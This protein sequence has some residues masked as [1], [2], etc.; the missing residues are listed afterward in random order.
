MSYVEVTEEG[1]FSRIKNSIKGIV[2]GFILFMAAFP[3]LLWNECNA[4]EVAESLEEGAGAV[5]SV[6][7][8]KIDASKEG[9]LIHTTGVVQTKDALRDEA[10]GVAATGVKLE[11]D[12]EIYQWVE[13]CSSKSE[14]KLGGKKVTE[15]TCDYTQEWRESAVDSS[16]FKDPKYKKRNQGTSLV[17]EKEVIPAKNVTVGAFKLTADQIESWNLGPEEK[18][19]VEQKHLRAARDRKGTLKLHDGGYYLGA[20]PARPVVGDQRITYEVVRPNSPLSVV[21]QQ[22]G[23]TFASFKTS[24]GK[25]I[26]LHK[27]GKVTADQM[28]TAAQEANT[29]MLWFMRLA[30][31]LG[32]FFGIS[33]ILRPL[34]V[35]ADVV[36]FVGSL[37]GAGTTLV[38][39]FL[40]VPLAL[41]TIALG[42]FVARPLLSIALLVLGAL[43]VGGLIF[44]VL[45]AR[46]KN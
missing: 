42:W 12:V 46:S 2:T 33:M 28:F 7:S 22:S 39:L 45:K 34:S 27:T 36:P 31:F 44:L 25:G 29:M 14:K 18:F 15:T 26:L 23:N 17:Y 43:F 38:A 13:K 6:S 41:F 10:L 19:V 3:C 5:V 4:V 32:L 24:N 11:R 8:A 35:V 16:T 40:A 37:V 21:A 30:G 20:D 1:W 9:K